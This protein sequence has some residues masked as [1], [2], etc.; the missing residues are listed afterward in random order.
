MFES[1][2]KILPCGLPMVDLLRENPPLYDMYDPAFFVLL[3]NETVRY[4]LSWP[5][6]PKR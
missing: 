3:E 4:F 5:L 2:S 6:R 1:T